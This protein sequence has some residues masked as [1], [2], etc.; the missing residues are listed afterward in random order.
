M[1]DNFILSVYMYLFW[2][3]YINSLIADIVTQYKNG[4][5]DYNTAVKTGY[6]RVYQTANPDFNMEQIFAVDSCYRDMPTI[7][8]VM[9]LWFFLCSCV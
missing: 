9:F 5:I 1:F 2:C 6:E 4:E 3:A 8:S 7:D